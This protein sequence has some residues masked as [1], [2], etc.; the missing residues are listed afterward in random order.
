[1]ITAHYRSFI[2]HWH[3]VNSSSVGH[4]LYINGRWWAVCSCSYW[5]C[6]LDLRPHFAMCLVVVFSCCV[7]DLFIITKWN[8]A[9]Y[10]Q[11]KWH[12][13]LYSV[14]FVWRYTNETVL[15]MKSHLCSLILNKS[16]TSLIIAYY[17][18]VVVSSC[19]LYFDTCYL[20]IFGLYSHFIV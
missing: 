16:L 7:G 1:M 15:Q 11:E 12:T 19:M 8:I 6:I 14:L 9:L 3:V 10:K 2:G 17:Y 13:R 5:C 20:A 18:I 4:W